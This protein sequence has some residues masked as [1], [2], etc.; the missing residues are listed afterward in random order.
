MRTV[1]SFI[2]TSSFAKYYIKHTK[3]IKLTAFIFLSLL[4]FLLPITILYMIINVNIDSINS[5][6]ID[7]KL[8]DK[9]YIPH[10]NSEV[11]SKNS[12]NKKVTNKSVKT[13]T[14]KN[15]NPEQIENE[16]FNLAHAIVDSL[17]N[18]FNNYTLKLYN[19]LNDSTLNYNAFRSGFQG[20]TIMKH[21]GQIENQQ[22][23]TV[24][25]FSKSANKERFFVIDVENK[26]IVY[27]TLVA[28]G[29]NTGNVFARKFSNRVHS[30]QSSI[31]FFI[32]DEIYTGKQGLS[33][34][35]NGLERC[36][37]KVRQRG[38]VIHGADYVSHRFIKNNGRLGRSNGCPAVPR[39]LNEEI[40]NTIKG[41]SCFFVYYPD[42]Q[43]FRTSKFVKAT[44]YLSHFLD[45]EQQNEV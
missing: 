14:T 31:G 29:R 26:K 41:K 37:N 30:N 45:S 36:N 10:K 6:N 35:L 20:Y 1:L 25:D 38:V 12:S 7:Y 11:N 9:Y 42:K 3:Q 17:S 22:Y 28:H 32:T 40:I 39:E 5:D 19:T 4:M 24:V 34:R 27:K 33:M 2:A 15:N 16:I 43:Y 18:S 21:S 23:M 44:N 13:Q 8:I